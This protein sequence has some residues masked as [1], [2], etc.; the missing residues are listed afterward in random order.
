MNLNFP[1]PIFRVFQFQSLGS[2]LSIAHPIDISS[3]PTTDSGVGRRGGGRGGGGRDGGFHGRFSFSFQLNFLGSFVTGAN[4]IDVNDNLQPLQGEGLFHIR[5]LLWFVVKLR[6][7]S[8][9]M[10][11]KHVL[12]KS[13]TKRM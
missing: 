1:I 3:Q 5:C 9:D 11:H 8:L 6:Q 7:R 12:S 2:F 4:S 10:S 13:Y